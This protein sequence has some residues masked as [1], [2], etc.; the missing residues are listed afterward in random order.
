[1][2]SETLTVDLVKETFQLY[3]CVLKNYFEQLIAIADCLLLSSDPLVIT[4]GSIFFQEMFIHFDEFYQQ[5]VVQS[6]IQH[7]CCCGDRTSSVDSPATAALVVLQELSESNWEHLV[8]FSGFLVTLLEFIEYMALPQVKKVMELLAKMAYGFSMS[9]ESK[10]R[11][12]S[13]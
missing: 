12:Y 4:H 13:I 1:M 2:R 11:L 8:R 3:D 7:V 6:L 10:S 9:D 5:E